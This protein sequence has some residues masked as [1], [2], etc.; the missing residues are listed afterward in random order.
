MKMIR[1]A[2][3]ACMGIVMALVTAGC[4]PS[5][6]SNVYSR[7]E[8]KQVQVAHEGTV[9]MVRGVQIEGTHSGIGAIAGGILG[10]GIGSTIGGGTGQT[11]A[12]AAGTV[13]GALAGGAAEEGATRQNGLE[14][15]VKLDN[16]EVVSIV[17]AADVPFAKGDRV[18]VLRRPDGSARV[19]Q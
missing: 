11:L 19:L 9:V 18:T 6:S 7:D 14:I 1:L 5:L 17:Q 12:R 3:T 4:A 10:Y 8:A 2:A 13:A 15:T 16:G